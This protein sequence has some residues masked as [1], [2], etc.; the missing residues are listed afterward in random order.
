M[1]NNI[2]EA[3][4][5]SKEYVVAKRGDTLK[6]TVKN[7]FKPDKEVVKAV[8]S[9][10]FHVREGETVGFSGQNGAG[11]TTTIKMLTGTLFPSSGSCS[12]NGFDPTKRQDSFK[13]SISVVMGNRSQLFPDLTPRDYLNLLK[14]MYGIENERFNQTVHELAKILNVEAKLDT[15]TR[16]LSLG[17]RM[18][19]EFL[20]GVSTNP[21]VLFLDEPTIGL[22]VL[23]K[24]DIRKF[25]QKINK[26]DN[27][28]IFLTSHDMEDIAAV[29]DRLIIV[30][31]GKVM[32]DGK[33]EEL[34]NK[35]ADY[36]YISFLKSETFK[37]SKVLAKII[38]EDDLSIT[39]KVKANE[40]DQI[41][42]E[43]AR[44]GQGSNYQ[45]SDLKLDD[46]ILELFE[47]EKNND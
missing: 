20:A 17:E 2:I 1:E 21:K 6:A 24:R 27:L 44:E 15:Q 19:V 14:S 35:F 32:W 34:F 4:N 41:I 22:D 5:L 18:K 9:L 23:A 31:K 47:E 11:K 43:L 36:K 3:K 7:I 45:I 46:I 8:S 39:V 30:N 10:N 40:I 37:A 25:L 28:T 29:C 12:V 16:K 38:D 26:K 13:K 33:K 42:S